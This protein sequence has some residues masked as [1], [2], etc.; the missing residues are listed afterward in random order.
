MIHFGA[1]APAKFDTGLIR[2]AAVLASAYH[3]AR[4]NN[5]SVWWG[6]LW[7]LGAYVAPIYG[8]S[9]VGIAVA[10]GFGQPRFKSNPARRRAGNRYRKRASGRGLK[11]GAKARRARM[12]RAANKIR[13]Q[14]LK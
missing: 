10:Q 3:G 14:G 5:G 13:R 1:D 12:R 7:A 8:V 4:R 2:K 11:R 6:L 9:A